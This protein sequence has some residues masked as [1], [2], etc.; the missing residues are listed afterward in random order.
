MQINHPDCHLL[1]E[2]EQGRPCRCTSCTGDLGDEWLCAFDCLLLGGL[3]VSLIQV[4]ND[5]HVASRSPAGLG[6]MLRYLKSVPGPAGILRLSR[7]PMPP[8]EL[9]DHGSREP[10]ACNLAEEKVA[11]R[12]DR[13]LELLNDLNIASW[14]MCIFGTQS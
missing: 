11:N 14:R 1:K 6:V 5:A 8:F 4:L 9:S 10:H 13:S 7:V 2:L 3:Q 12:S